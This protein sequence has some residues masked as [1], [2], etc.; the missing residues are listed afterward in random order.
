MG[1]REKP[2]ETRLSYSQVFHI[3][4]GGTRLLRLFDII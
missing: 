3:R 2:S 4:K 1:E